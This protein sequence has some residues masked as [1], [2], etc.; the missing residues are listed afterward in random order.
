MSRN[1]NLFVFAIAST[2]ASGFLSESGDA[3]VEVPECVTVETEEVHPLP[4]VSALITGTICVYEHSLS[5]ISSVWRSSRLSISICFSC[6]SFF[7]YLLLIFL[8]C[9]IL[10]LSD[11]SFFSSSGFPGGKGGFS[12]VCISV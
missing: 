8:E 9:D 7:L 11:L 1:T 3:G 4:E 12:A 5:K 6:S 10:H 2:V